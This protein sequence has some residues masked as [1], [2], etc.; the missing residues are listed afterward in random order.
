MITEIRKFLPAVLVAAALVTTALPTQAEPPEWSGNPDAS[1]TIKTMPGMMRYDQAEIEVAP[2][3]KVKLTLDNPDDLQHNL[4]LLKPSKDDK[5]GQKF[6]QQVWQ[7]GEEGIAL[8]WV[9]KDH[10]RIIVASKLL[11]PESSEDLY[12]VAPKEYGDYPFV[13]TVPGHSM[14][15]KGI[16]KIQDPSAK[17]SLEKL[18]YKIYKGDWKKLP[19]FSKLKPIKTG[20][21][22]DGIIDLSV[23]KKHKGGSI[24]VVFEGK[25][26]VENE[27]DH[28]FFLSSDDGVRLIIDGEGVIDLDGIHPAGNPTEAMERLQE[29]I[30][31]I[32]VPWFDAGGHRVLALSVRSKTIG[33][34]PLS[35]D[36]NK[37]KP[38]KA[39][40]PPMLLTSKNGEAITHRAFIGGV[41]PRAIAVGY[42]GGV[43]LAWDAD[44]MNLSVLWR[45]GFVDVAPHWNGRG[46]GSNIAGY[47]KISP[48]PGLPMQVLE[49]LDEPWQSDSKATIKYE[50]DTTD[51]Q[52]EIT[53]D[54]RHPDY[55]FDGYTLDEKRF[56]T[57][58]YTYQEN[59]QMEESFQPLHSAGLDGLQRTIRIKGKTPAAAHLRIA[60]GG[61]IKA[62]DDSNWIECGAY[63][64]KF[65]ESS[66][67]PI[68]REIEGKT[69]VLAAL[70][71]D[72]EDQSL[73]ITYQWTKPIGGR[74][75]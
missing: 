3:T 33:N 28:R 55:H 65:S 57:L 74:K 10:P 24:G 47:D 21:L 71:G 39:S 15:M 14:L 60:S 46:S 38:K 13:C 48:A 70:I 23:A 9:P 22:P 37:K 41:S 69:E 7:L 66:L 19:D 67:K 45:G 59:V 27:E 61:D 72:A 18:T 43:N 11:D 63:R 16:L 62:S 35:K 58:R 54:I 56:P 49:S 42:P 34:A 17:A 29:G 52:K 51:P 4:V 68:I 40:P 12:F 53:F 5:D 50:R 20:K 26:R 73:V 36:A 6:S 2:G 64:I 32:R 1:I 30:H 8:G 25:L 44:L 31:E 75:K